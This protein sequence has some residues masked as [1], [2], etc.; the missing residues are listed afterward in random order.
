[1]LYGDG[2]LF[3]DSIFQL[4]PSRYE[5]ASKTLGGWTK[6]ICFSARVGQALRIHIP[7]PHEYV[8]IEANE[9][10]NV[11]PLLLQRG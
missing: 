1:M 10:L 4:F 11:H 6:R 3:R 2:L 9:G 8:A 5:R 7:L